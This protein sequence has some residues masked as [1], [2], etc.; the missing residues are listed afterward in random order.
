MEIR[1]ESSL[2]GYVIIT[3]QKKTTIFATDI[4]LPDVETQK[5]DNKMKVFKLIT[6]VLLFSLFITGCM[7]REERFYRDKALK[8]IKKDLTNMKVHVD[9][10][11]P[12]ETKMFNGKLGLSG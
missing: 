8:I 2:F 4:I 3:Y 5:K 12:I 7:S 11:R 1:V 6:I 10:N 9:S